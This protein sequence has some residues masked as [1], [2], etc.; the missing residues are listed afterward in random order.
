MDAEANPADK[1]SRDGLD[2]DDYGYIAQE[3][4][5]PAW[6]SEADEFRRF[7]Q[8][9]SHCRFIVCDFG[10]L[11]WFDTALMVIHGS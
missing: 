5:V 10:A 6:Q 3:A 1:L 8:I 9:R 11:L 2:A 7:D 4:C